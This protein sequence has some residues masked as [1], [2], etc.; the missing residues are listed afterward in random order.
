M[1]F[2]VEMS[3]LGAKELAVHAPRAQNGHCVGKFRKHKPALGKDV[4]EPYEN[5]M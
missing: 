4:L 1:S 5:G 2:G 3:R